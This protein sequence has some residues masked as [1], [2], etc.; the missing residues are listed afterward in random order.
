MMLYPTLA[1]LLETT[2]NRYHLVNLVAKRARQITTDANDR[3]EMLTEK[4]VTMAV[5]EIYGRGHAAREK[6]E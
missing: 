4:P 5:N 1:E 2:G 6:G 3:G